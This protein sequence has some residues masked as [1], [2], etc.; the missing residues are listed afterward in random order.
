MKSVYPAI[1]AETD[2][3]HVPFVVYVPDFDRM[4]QGESLSDAMEMAADL[5]ETL[6]VELKD[7]GKPL[8]GASPVKSID[9]EKWA[10]ENAPGGIKNVVVTFVTSA[11][12]ST[13]R[14]NIATRQNSLTTNSVS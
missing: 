7:T 13:A 14:Q 9:A 10:R 1:I 12:H 11:F 2:D 3:P 8:P 5:I 6:A 4:T